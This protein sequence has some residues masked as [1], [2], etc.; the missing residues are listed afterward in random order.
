[1]SRSK[2]LSGASALAAA[3]MAI[4]GFAH[5]DTTMATSQVYGGGS[6]LI[7]PYLRVV[8]DCYGQPA[9][10][11]VQGVS[12]YGAGTESFLTLAPFS[13]PGTGA[14]HTG[15]QNC[16]TL[17]TDPTTQIN[18]LNAGSGNGELGVFTHD[19]TTDYSVTTDGNN[20]H[21]Q[22]PSI[23]YGAGD[24]G[25]GLSE[26]TSYLNGGNLSQ[27]TGPGA[28]VTILP[29]GSSTTPSG[30]TYANPV[31]L[32]GKFIQFPISIDAVA[33]AYSPVYKVANNAVTNQTTNYSFFIDH[34][35][36]DKS[37]GL[38][39]SM[40]VLC[41]IMNGSITNWN[42]PAI[43]YLNG[44]ISLMSK[45]D[46]SY[47]KPTPATGVGFVQP[48]FSVPIQLD[49]RSDSSGTTSIFFRALAKQCPAT[50]SLT[51]TT[52]TSSTETFSGY[53]Q[54]YT[55]A[56][57]KKLPSGIRVS[58]NG[59]EGANP[60]KFNT[61]SGSTAVATALGVLPTPAAGQTALHG[62]LGYIGTDYVLPE[63]N[64]AVGGV[65]NYNLNVADI[66]AK[67]N[68]AGAYVTFIEPTSTSA[69]AAFGAG[70]TAILPPQSTAAGA[71]T[72]TA[73]AANSHGLRSVPSDWA[74][75]IS[76]TYT[77]TLPNGTQSAPVDTPLANP[78]AATAYALVG[79]TNAFLNTCYAQGVDGQT[80]NPNVNDNATTLKA[81]FTSYFTSATYNTASTG[82]LPQAG[83]GILPAA[84]RTAIKATFLTPTV[85]TKTVVGTDSLNLNILKVGTPAHTPTGTSTPVGGQCLVVSPGA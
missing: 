33:I 78:A 74:E 6:T 70:T 20:N 25:I 73:I 41:A 11:V 60:G 54:Y 28:T 76:T 48:N 79:T 56:G 62:D 4:A 72:T 55:A 14:G 12:P 18:Y 67:T 30:T 40:P 71:Y 52:G 51:L 35:N 19:I 9:D 68:T 31:A 5:A 81:F 46:P 77:Y 61:Y 8:G 15:A 39:L 50:G 21:Q 82:L 10:L 64:A 57:G 26:V 75:P 85:S 22:Y 27:T 59:A 58:T 49:G 42:D 45:T 53:T 2:L 44:N 83:F 63:A 23:E 80:G 7:G 43:Q 24:Y 65:N 17:H 34:P 1:M 66:A 37:G 29:P 32:Y 36:A 3:G 38:R 69:L 13:F 47:V 16:S 84:W